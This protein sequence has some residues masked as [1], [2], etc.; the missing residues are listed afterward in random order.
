[1]RKTL[2]M[3]AALLGL[4]AGPAL[5]QTTMTTTQ[6]PPSSNSGQAGPQPDGSLPRSAET[7]EYHAAGSQQDGRSTATAHHPHH[8]QRT[9]AD[10]A[11]MRH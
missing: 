8:P 1:M 3:T 11:A 9:A 6:T 2:L 4:V 10:P 5:A 7:S